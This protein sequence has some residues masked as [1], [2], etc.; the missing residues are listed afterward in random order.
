MII[1]CDVFYFIIMKKEMLALFDNSAH[2][3]FKTETI[4][5]L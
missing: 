1:Q 2:L 5:D 4:K 3:N